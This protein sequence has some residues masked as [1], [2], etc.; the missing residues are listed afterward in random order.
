MTPNRLA[1]LTCWALWFALL[2]HAWHQDR[3]AHEPPVAAPL[4]V[5]TPE[6]H[7]THL[8]QLWAGRWGVDSAFA[9][10]LSRAEN[11]TADP[12][13][14]STAGAV[15]YMQVMPV[16]WS[17]SYLHHL[18]AWLTDTL[19]LFHPSTNA[20]VGVGIL[21]RELHICR[22]DRACAVRR[23]HGDPPRWYR[24]MILLDEVQP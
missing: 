14:V 5:P 20:C 1:A 11:W 16:Y 22:G 3:V 4:L 18:C 17:R 21:A 24:D 6:E 13:A 9:L 8:V 12:R 23:Y 15:G 2:L 7:R 10:R 19:D